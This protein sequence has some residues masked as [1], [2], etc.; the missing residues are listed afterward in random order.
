MHSHLDLC[1]RIS[2]LLNTC[3]QFYLLVQ[4]YSGG[5]N[6]H[7]VLSHATAATAPTA[8]EAEDLRKIC[9]TLRI[10]PPAA[11]EKFYVCKSYNVIYHGVQRDREQR[12]RDCHIA[13]D[14]E[15]D[16]V[17]GPVRCYG[18]LQYF[19][20]LRHGEDEGLKI[21]LAYVEWFNMNIAERSREGDA[22]Y[23]PWIWNTYNR[24]QN[25]DRFV[26][27][28]DVVCKVALLPY[29]GTRTKRSVVELL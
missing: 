14:Y 20:S 17:D 21:F 1:M 11:I 24:D 9:D 2:A 22:H 29:N 19:I 5:F 8:R 25:L 15:F 12:F 23:E 27:I 28:S 3:M 4:R 6:N 10:S 7:I 13:C 26:P 16:G 18:E